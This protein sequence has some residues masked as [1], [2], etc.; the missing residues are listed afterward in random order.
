MQEQ[1]RNITLFELCCLNCHALNIKELQSCKGS[2]GNSW[3]DTTSTVKNSLLHLHEPDLKVFKQ[4]YCCLLSESV[5]LKINRGKLYFLHPKLKVKVDQLCPT[6]CDPMDYS[7]L[8]SSVPGESPGKSTGMGCHALLRGILRLGELPGQLVITVYQIAA[9][10][11]MQNIKL[12]QLYLFQSAE[13]ILY[14]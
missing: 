8:G 13:M 4:F 7:P 1:E 14:L 10:Y 11:K 6:L 9:Y 5:P 3:W 12:S 2:R